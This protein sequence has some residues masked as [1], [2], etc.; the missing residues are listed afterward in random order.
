MRYEILG[1]KQEETLKMKLSTEDIYFLWCLS[2]GVGIKED[3]NC[4]YAIS[5]EELTERYSLNLHKCKSEEV[6]KKKFRKLFTGR[7]SKVVKYIC[8]TDNNYLFSINLQEYKKIL[9]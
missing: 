4:I 5:Y 3:E 6:I 1:Y 9:A 2:E 8:Y 7:L